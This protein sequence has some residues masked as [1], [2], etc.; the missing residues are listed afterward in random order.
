MSSKKFNNDFDLNI[1]N[2]KQDETTQKAFEV[3]KLMIMGNY[4]LKDISKY[5]TIYR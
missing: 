5:T 1:E 3:A 2:N 4:S